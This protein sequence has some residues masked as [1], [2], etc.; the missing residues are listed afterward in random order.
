MKHG[1]TRDRPAKEYGILYF[2][3]EAAGLMDQLPC[4]VIRGV[5]Y[6]DSHKN[7][8]WQGYAALTGNSS[9]LCQNPSLGR[10]REPVPE[11]QKACRMVP[12]ERNPRFLGRYNEVEALQQRILPSWVR[13]KCR[14]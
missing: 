8:Q 10:F 3:M 12:F 2:E 6:C 13:I 14:K 1:R 5:C 9:G 4:L 7:K 11:F